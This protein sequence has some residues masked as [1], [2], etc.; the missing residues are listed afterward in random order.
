MRSAA[1]VG[2][3]S[4]PLTLSIKLGYSAGQFIDG[5]VNNALVV[6]LLFYVTAVC[7]LSGALAGVALS[8][9]IIVDAIMDPA[10]GALSDGWRSR[11]GRRLPFMLAGSVPIAVT[12]VLIFML[13]AGLS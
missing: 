7:G 9:G 2:D 8:A 1:A 12:F 4:T 13:P 6:F 11:L 3:R 10:I 5:I